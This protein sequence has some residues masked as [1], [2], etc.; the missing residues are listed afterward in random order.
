MITEDAYERLAMLKEGTES[1]SDVINKITGKVSLFSIAGLLTEKEADKLEKN[2]NE[3]RKR[4]RHRL[5]RTRK[6]LAA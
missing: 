2:I 4:S 1:F 6:E 3:L 5:E